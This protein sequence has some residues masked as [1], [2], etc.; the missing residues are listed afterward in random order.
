MKKPGRP[1]RRRGGSL[2]FVR[3]P[4]GPWDRVRRGGGGGFRRTRLDTGVETVA[5]GP[6][7]VKMRLRPVGDGGR[8]LASHDPGW[9]WYTDMKPAR[10]FLG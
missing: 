7:L 4:G 8:V 6:R 9:P 5:A 2:G 10:A 3:S 1:Q